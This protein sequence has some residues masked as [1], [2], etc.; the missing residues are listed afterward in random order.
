MILPFAV[1][2][3]SFCFQYFVIYNIHSY[4]LLKRILSVTRAEIAIK[5]QKYPTPPFGVF[6]L[7]RTREAGEGLSRSVRHAYMGEGVHKSK[8]IGKKVPCCM[9]FVIFSYAK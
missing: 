7:V 9:Y 6:R 4:S 2:F 5:N 8:Y 1:S 3:L